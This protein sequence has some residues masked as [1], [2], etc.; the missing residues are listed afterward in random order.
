MSLQ[1]DSSLHHWV[2]MV[3]CH[4]LV[5]G[6]GGI[7]PPINFEL[8]K[9]RRPSCPWQ[10]PA[11]KPITLVWG[12][13]NILFHASGKIPALPTAPHVR[14]SQ[15]PM[16]L[17]HESRDLCPD[18]PKPEQVVGDYWRTYP[19]LGAQAGK[20]A[21]GKWARKEQGELFQNCFVEL[22]VTEM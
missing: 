1:S 10:V 13:F 3:P 22:T 17:A 11:S 14:R 2:G 16:C 9:T 18:E 4:L 21:G 15:I 19:C 6:E 12:S 7:P 8:L 5:I 20:G